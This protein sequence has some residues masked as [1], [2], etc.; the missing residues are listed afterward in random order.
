MW[1]LSRKRLDFVH[2]RLRQNESWYWRQDNKQHGSEYSFLL[3]L[4]NYQQFHRAIFT[5][6]TY[7]RYCELRGGGA[8]KTALSDL[9]HRL[10]RLGLSDGF[11]NMSLGIKW[12]QYF[13]T[14][15]ENSWG[16]RN[17]STCPIYQYQGIHIKRSIFINI[18]M[19]CRSLATDLETPRGAKFT[20]YLPH[21]LSFICAVNLL[22]CIMK[23]WLP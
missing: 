6:N 8:F 17:G 20:I 1:R 2:V 22:G 21:F 23:P 3:E 4:G 10:L 5:E 12:A 15:K 9:T 16:S 7:G 13:T 19:I 14:K 18:C 11:L